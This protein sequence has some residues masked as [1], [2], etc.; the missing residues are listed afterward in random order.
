LTELWPQLIRLEGGERLIEIQDT[1][2]NE[3][4]AKLLHWGKKSGSVFQNLGNTIQ[5]LQ[6]TIFRFY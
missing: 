1:A 2:S 4:N 3:D 5:L 6:I